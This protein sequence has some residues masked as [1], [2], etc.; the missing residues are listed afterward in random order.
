MSQYFNSHQMNNRHGIP[1]E[2]LS[3]IRER[4]V[5]CVYCHKKMIYP[6][7][8]ENVADSATI[9]HFRENGPFY[10]WDGM[11]K[12]DLAICC[13]SC[14]ASRGKKPLMVWF[15]EEYCARKGIS[16]ETVAEP[17]GKYIQRNNLSAQ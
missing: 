15:E 14:N 8:K 4:D 3:K 13:G 5:D 11:N 2:V 9:E 16:V 6:Y 17:V 10:W 12:E 7:E 1:K